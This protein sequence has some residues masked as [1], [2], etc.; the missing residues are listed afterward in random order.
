LVFPSRFPSLFSS[1]S[2]REGESED[3][4][5]AGREWRGKC[6]VNINAIQKSEGEVESEMGREVVM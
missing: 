4:L 5:E 6:E 1:L 2:L 3:N